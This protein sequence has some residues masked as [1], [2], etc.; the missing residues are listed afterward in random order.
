MYFV[1]EISKL[2]S[3]AFI[4]SAV[5]LSHEYFYSYMRISHNCAWCFRSSLSA[6]SKHYSIAEQSEDGKFRVCLLFFFL[7]NLDYFQIS[8]VPAFFLHQLPI[9]TIMLS[10][11][12]VDNLSEIFFVKDCPPNELGE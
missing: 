3:S 6:V 10:N 4:T 2:P 1:V 8:P 5:D 12:E 7:D 9:A 11:K